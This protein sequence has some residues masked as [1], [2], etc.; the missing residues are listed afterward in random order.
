MPTR[1]WIAFSLGLVLCAASSSADTGDVGTVKESPVRFQSVY[2]DGELV[3]EPGVFHPIEA[4]ETVLPLLADQAER[5]RGKRILEIG[6]G[7]GIVSL[8]LCQLG[9]AKVVATDIE[10][11]A[12][13]TA[14]ANEQRLGFAGVMEVR[15]VPLSDLSAYSVL[16][17]GERFDVIVSNP[18]YSLDLDAERNDAVTDR[19]DLGFSIVRGLDERLS[20]GGFAL[21][22]YASLYYHEV[23]R[24]FAEHEGF[25]VWSDPSPV[26]T[27]WEAATLFNA[28]TKRLLASEGLAA[29]AI[30]FDW[31]TEKSVQLRTF[32]PTRTLFE[33]LRFVV[34]GDDGF[35]REPLFPGATSGQYPGWMRIERRTRDDRSAQSTW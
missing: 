3:V 19:G 30:R 20:D 15:Q 25:Q 33:R 21:L 28:Y 11:A 7:S 4:E 16:A 10:P 6:T 13:A 35:E 29:D 23:M 12:I 18:P 17:P 26:L 1:A 27:P 5:F 31:R 8:Y 2:L 32:R 22:L 14:R 24:K 34:T 9:A